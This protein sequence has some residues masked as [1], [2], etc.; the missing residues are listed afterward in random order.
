[1]KLIGEISES[2]QEQSN[3]ISQINQAIQQLNIA[4][5]Q[6]AASSNL[7]TNNSK[8]LTRRTEK[9]LDSVSYF[10][11]DK[12]LQSSELENVA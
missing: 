5:Q 9:L 3:G 10:K 1:M 12:Q 11:L 6:N 7:L 4:G 8:I 2:S